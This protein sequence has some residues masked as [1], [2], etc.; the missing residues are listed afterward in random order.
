MRLGD[1]FTDTGQLLGGIR[2]RTRSFKFNPVIFPPPSARK[3]VREHV[4]FISRHKHSFWHTV[5]PQH[6][7]A[8]WMTLKIMF[9]RSL[10]TCQKNTTVCNIQIIQLVTWSDPIQIILLKEDGRGE[11]RPEFQAVWSS[12][13]ER[14]AYRRQR[15]GLQGIFR[16]TLVGTGLP[17][18]NHEGINMGTGSLSTFL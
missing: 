17:W 3:H 18:A 7:F 2:V 16:S 9:L 11:T 15:E 8:M 13:P 14:G 12:F 4:C 10:Q 5:G 6:I 1:L